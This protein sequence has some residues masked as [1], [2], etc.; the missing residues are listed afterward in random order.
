MRDLFAGMSAERQNT[1]KP[2]PS[3]ETIPASSSLPDYAAFCPRWWR[4]C[5]S[6]LDYL[7][8]EHIRFCRAHNRRHHGSEVVALVSEEAGEAVLPRQAPAAQGGAWW[9][10]RKPAG[11]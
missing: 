5:F 2:G 4:E 8:A 6:C 9:N 10:G 3:A 11:Q 1:V 7:G